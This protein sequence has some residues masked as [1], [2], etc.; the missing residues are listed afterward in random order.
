MFLILVINE[1]IYLVGHVLNFLAVSLAPV[2]LVSALGGIQPFFMLVF[3]IILSIFWPKIIKE[4]ITK[5]TLLIK[6]VSVLLIFLGCVAI[7]F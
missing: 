1:V 7:S 3:G 2:A 5:K 6:F 4:D